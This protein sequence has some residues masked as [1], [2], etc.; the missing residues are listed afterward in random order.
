[1]ISTEKEYVLPSENEWKDFRGGVVKV[2]ANSRS[3][4]GR[5]HEDGWERTCNGAQPP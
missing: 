2:G 4:R 1:M 5:T 3:F